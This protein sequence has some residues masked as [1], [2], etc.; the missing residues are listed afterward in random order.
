MSRCKKLGTVI[1][2]ELRLCYQAEP[3]TLLLLQEV[4][5]GERI[6]FADF[7]LCRITSPH[8]K[9]SFNVIDCNN[10]LVGH[11]YFGLHVHDDEKNLI[12]LKLENKVLY[13]NRIKDV[14]ESIKGTF[15]LIFNNVT[16]VDLAVD[17]DFNITYAIRRCMKR[18]GT[19]T[20]INGKAI[21]DPTDVI[22]DMFLIYKTTLKRIVDPSIYLM[23]KKA[24]TNKSKGL[25]MKSYNKKMEIESQ[26]EKEYILQYYDYPKQLHRL[27][28]HQNRDEIIDFCVKYNIELSEEMLF[29]NKTLSQ[30]F[31]YHLSSILR[32]TEGRRKIGWKEILKM[33]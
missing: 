10:K 6:D 3:E 23:Q 30:M 11:L 18:S 27:E 31:Y 2:D 7:S 26:G 32:F 28:V 20:I 16:A 19:T 33:Q 29:N 9:Y 24:S 17:L 8:I 14:I 1:I 12:W 21:K 4:Q 13:E 5:L 22:K 15:N 25:H